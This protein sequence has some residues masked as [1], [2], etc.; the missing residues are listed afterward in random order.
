M[1]VS[2]VGANSKSLFFYPKIKGQLEDE[3][4]KLAFDKIH[5]FQP[6][7]LIRQKNRIRPNEVKAIKFINKIN[8]IGLIK[9]QRPMPIEVLA[10]KMINASLK[11]S[12]NKIST[13]LPKM[14]FHEL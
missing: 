13:Y 2:S 10:E 12:P 1:L 9:G 14:I 8:K 5:I 4:K 7:I 3:V 11:R 6:P